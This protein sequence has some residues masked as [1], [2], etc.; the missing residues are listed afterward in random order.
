MRRLSA[1]R[2][3]AKFQTAISGGVSQSRQRA[4]FGLWPALRAGK[5]VVIE[6]TESDEEFAP[7]R[8]IARLAGYR[9]VVTTPL[10]TQAKDLMGVVATHFVRVH[11]P[12]AL[13]LDTFEGYSFS[14]GEHLSR[15]VGRATLASLALNMNRRLYGR[16]RKKVIDH[17]RRPIE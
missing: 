7:F 2:G 4:R 12:T 17:R 15:L 3:S 14:A 10:R 11:R 9:S 16:A 5:T 13:E 1:H 6:D 8:S